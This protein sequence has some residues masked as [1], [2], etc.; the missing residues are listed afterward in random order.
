MVR[1]G[2]GLLAFDIEI[3]IAEMPPFTAV[4]SGELQ[5]YVLSVIG[6][7]VDADGGP[8]FPQ[9]VV[10]IGIPSQGGIGNEV[11]NSALGV[12]DGI[13]LVEDAHGETGLRKGSV[14]GVFEHGGIVEHDERVKR[15]VNVE[16]VD[17]GF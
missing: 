12:D 11:G 3:G 14:V 7:E 13:V 15:S 4:E 10:S 6:G 16:V 5:P 2:I 9:Y 1:R 17:D 8:V